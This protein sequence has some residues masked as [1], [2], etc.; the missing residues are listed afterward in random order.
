MPPLG[1]FSLIRFERLRAAGKRGTLGPSSRYLLGVVQD[2]HEEERAMVVSAFSA[3]R[4]SALL[5]PAV[6]LAQAPPT[7]KPPVAP[8]AEQLDPNACAQ[9]DT[10]THRREG[11]RGRRSRSRTRAAI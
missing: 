10:P 9:A 6:A 2:A 4:S 1:H 11:R 7:T 3:W 8:K 5:L